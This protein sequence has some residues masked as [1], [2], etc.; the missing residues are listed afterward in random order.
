M[1]MKQTGSPTLE[2]ALNGSAG[3][4]KRGIPAVSGICGRHPSVPLHD[5]ARFRRSCQSVIPFPEMMFDHVLHDA[6]PQSIPLLHGVAIVHSYRHP[7]RPRSQHPAVSSHSSGA[8]CLRS[9]TCRT[10]RCALRAHQP[11][12]ARRSVCGCRRAIGSAK[13]ARSPFMSCERSRLSSC[14]TMNSSALPA[15]YGRRLDSFRA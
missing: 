6:A 11:S 3:S 12:C 13:A 9:P 4:P 10:R 8:S 15:I 14:A 2:G 7:T 1:R 5:G